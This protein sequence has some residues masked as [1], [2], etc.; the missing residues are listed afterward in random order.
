M[1][2]LIAGVF[3]EKSFLIKLQDLI[4][5]RPYDIVNLHLHVPTLQGL[6]ENT[7]AH[8]DFEVASTSQEDVTTFIN[9]LRMVV[10]ENDLVWV[11]RG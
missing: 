2:I 9:E 6:H 3:G 7:P 10:A 8:M 5:D 1:P 11:E 4:K